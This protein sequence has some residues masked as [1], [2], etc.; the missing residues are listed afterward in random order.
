MITRITGHLVRVLDDEVRL[1][2]GSFEYQVLVPEF[3]RRQLQTRAG[4]EVTLHTTQYLE[5][6]Q[7]G[8]R[9]VPRLIGFMTER[10]LAFF[11]LFCTVDKVGVRKAL[12]A[13]NRPVSDI[14]DAIHRQDVK[15]LTTL[16]GV[17]P[18]T[19]KEMLH[20]LKDEIGP[21]V[22]TPMTQAVAVDPAVSRV[23]EDAYQ[24]LL[25]LG[26]T[27]SEARGRLDAALEGGRS[28]RTVEDLL[29]AV[30]NRG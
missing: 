5:G 9:F 20:A 8:S 11:D 30:Y 4:N 10:D 3:V 16:P 18:S 12:K 26:H 27:P 1:A 7:A 15:W 24:A 29:V 28:F 23:I 25:S 14:A 22:E 19:A 6:N 13:L 17:G 21:F 2:A